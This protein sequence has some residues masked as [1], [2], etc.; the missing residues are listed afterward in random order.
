MV[1]VMF[2]FLMVEPSVLQHLTFSR[3]NR[4]SPE[5]RSSTMDSKTSRV[6][7]PDGRTT[8][9]RDHLRLGHWHI[10]AGRRQIIS[11]SSAHFDEDDT[12]GSLMVQLGPDRSNDTLCRV[13]ILT[14]LV[15]F[16]LSQYIPGFGTNLQCRSNEWASLGFRHLMRTSRPFL[17]WTI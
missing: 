2:S 7:V 5:D 14:I 15:A 12:R 9:N 8:L 11:V 4:L 6:L 13:V 1:F 3:C 16:N 10:L 17:F